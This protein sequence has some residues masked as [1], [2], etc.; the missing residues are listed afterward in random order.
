MFC[1]SFAMTVGLGLLTGAEDVSV[2]QITAKTPAVL[3]IKTGFSWVF[4]TKDQP[5]LILW[6]NGRLRQRQRQEEREAEMRFHL[7]KC[8]SVSATV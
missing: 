7:R 2:L 3:R 8:S 6:A 1:Y 5:G 4:A